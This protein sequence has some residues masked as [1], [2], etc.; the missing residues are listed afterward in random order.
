[1]N[2]FEVLV[3]VAGARRKAWLLLIGMR[4]LDES[5]A[6]ES[7]ADTAGTMTGRERLW[8]CCTVDNKTYYPPRW[9]WNTS[10]HATVT[11]GDNDALYSDRWPNRRLTAT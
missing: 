5:P 10:P 7:T 8:V 9:F 2:F 1:V 4:S 6:I 3:D 11:D